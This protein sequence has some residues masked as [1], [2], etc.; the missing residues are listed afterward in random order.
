MFPAVAS[1]RTPDDNVPVVPGPLEPDGKMIVPLPVIVPVLIEVLVVDVS[2]R[3]ASIL[4]VE[5]F[6]VTRLLLTV[7]SEVDTVTVPDVAIVR[8]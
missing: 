2:E 7:R 8:L 6:V 5:P 3:D 1:Y 4:S